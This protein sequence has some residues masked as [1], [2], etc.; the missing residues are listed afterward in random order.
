[1]FSSILNFLKQVWEKLKK[2]FVAIINFIQ[3]IANWFRVKFSR[4]KKK[5]PNVKPISLKIEKEL[6]KGN[7][8]TMDLGLEKDYVVVNTFYDEDTKE[9]IEEETEVVQSDRLDAD[10]IRAFGDKD[11]LVLS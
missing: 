2:I 8:N 10:T 5:H 7:Y 6:D 1:M 3:N 4:V 9:I 11:I